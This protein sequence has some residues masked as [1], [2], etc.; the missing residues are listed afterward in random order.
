MSFQKK[1][2]LKRLSITSIVVLLTLNIHS[3]KLK[4]YYIKYNGEKSTKLSGQYKRTVDSKGDVWIVNDY[5]LN[6]SLFRTG[7][8]L[9][10]KLTLKTG[11]FNNYYLNGKLSSTVAYKDNTKHGN[12]INYYITGKVSKSTSFEMGEVTGKWIW[13][14]Q[15]GSIKNE[16]ENITPNLLGEQYGSTAYVGGQKKLAEYINKLDFQFSKGYIALYNK[17]FVTFQ[18][19]EEGK[20]ND[21][22]IIIH[23]TKKMDSVIIEHLSKMPKWKASKIG[24]KF[25]TNYAVLPLRISKQGK[26]V[27]TDKVIGEA[28][29]KSGTEDYKVENYDKANF[30]IIQAIRRNHME[31]KYYFLL[32]HSYFKQKKM[33]FACEYWT[34]AH[35]LDKSIL[36]K[37]IKE[38]CNLE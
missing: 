22:D 33:D 7:N 38:F 20:V 3:Q 23:G 34:I 28:F 5:Y 1:I 15:D 11:V 10:K 31:A 12:Q 14:N 25:V 4:T 21:I 32:G 6:D 36:T 18:V 26:K 37:E 35:N 16:I 27:L 2:S 24:G 9:D 13:Y 17:T 8:Y 19:N 29:F 30:K